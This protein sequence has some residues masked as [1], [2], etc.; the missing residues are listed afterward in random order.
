VTDL[1]DPAPVA[2]DKL[3]LER[4]MRCYEGGI[5]AVVCTADAD[6]IPNVTYIS[7]VQQVDA[8][9]VALSNQ[10]MSKTSQNLAVNP[11]ANVLI[12]D[13]LTYQEYSLGLT[14]ERTER[15]GP[16]FDRLRDDVDQI[17]ETMG[18]QAV[19]K[20][21]AATI[22][23]VTSIEVTGP[24]HR[25][26]VVDD[27]PKRSLDALAEFAAL[28]GAANGLDAVV[29]D[30]VHGIDTILGYHHVSLLLTDETG[31]TV[32]VI[33]SRGFESPNI[34][35][36]IRLGDGA[37]GRPLTGESPQRTSGLRQMAKYSKTV[38]RS[39]EESGLDPG[40]VLPIPELEGVDSRIVV[41]IRSRGQLVGGLVVEDCR[42][43]AFHRA[44]ELVLTSA[45]TM[46][47]GA[48]EAALGDGPAGGTAA[49]ARPSTRRDD[50]PTVEA[51]ADP[52][53]VRCF[54][55]DGS[56]FVDGDYLIRGVA[57]R[58]MRALVAE[59]VA[60]G[61]V[62]FTNREL[63]LDPSL[64]LPGFKD[65]L[66]SRLTLLKRRLDEREAPCR[67]EKTGRGR[68]RLVVER[69]L[70]LETVDDG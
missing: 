26:P 43:A 12:I 63:R 9:R 47:A 44:D 6:G 56:T 39:F 38:R 70:E 11:L 24:I 42:V 1:A 30:A 34:G 8:D 19:F 15:R 25:E 67:I 5:P 46:L 40:D 54:D 17:A 29:E 62:D 14:Y 49:S 22:M 66:E 23:R 45:A 55:V 2:S 35:A 60:T 3:G 50:A 59:H 64:D 61:R 52:V 20:L 13:P 31:G 36:E 21:R 69:P 53:V 4:L 57:G 65:N 10:F 51:S 41:P 68:F 7:R 27:E 48:I 28:L 32:Y 58:I 18:L 33:A 37:I 16:V